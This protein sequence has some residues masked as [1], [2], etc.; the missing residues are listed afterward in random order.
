MET[1]DSRLFFG[2]DGMGV[3][4]RT[5]SYYTKLLVAIA[6][7]SSQLDIFSLRGLVQ[8]NLLTLLYFTYCIVLWFSTFL[9]GVSKGSDPKLCF[10][11]MLHGCSMEGY[12]EWKEEM[13]A[14]Y[15]DS[16]KRTVYWLDVVSTLDLD[17]PTTFPYLHFIGFTDF[18]E[19]SLQVQIV[20][21][22]RSSCLPL[23]HTRC[24][25][26]SLLPPPIR[27]SDRSSCLPLQ[28]TRCPQ[29]SLLPPPMIISSSW[30]SS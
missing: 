8:K 28:H 12:L 30:I 27:F 1:F 4:Q 17:F 5:H 21:N 9:L 15:F 2:L 23:Q 18:L 25:R 16:D 13:A 26:G 19:I 14:S 24:P 22:Q 29:G 3:A 10:N 20:R 11:T 6:F 7:F